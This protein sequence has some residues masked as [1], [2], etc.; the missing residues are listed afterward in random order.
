VVTNKDR[1]NSIRSSWGNSTY[2]N[3]Y[4]VKF[5]FLIG[6]S[7]SLGNHPTETSVKMLKEEEKFDDIILGDFHDSFHNLTYKGTFLKFFVYFGRIMAVI[8]IS[9]WLP[10]EHL[11]LP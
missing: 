11:Y 10:V 2:Y 5:I 8:L 9:T 6:I 3:D 7:T 1:R 4:P